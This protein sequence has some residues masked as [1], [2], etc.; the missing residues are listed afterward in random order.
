MLWPGTAALRGVA[1]CARARAQ[2]GGAS[3]GVGKF[4]RRACGRTTLRPGTA[5]LLGGVRFLLAAG[6]GGVQRVRQLSM[7]KKKSRDRSI[8]GV[9]RMLR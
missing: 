5:A 3:G 9:S 1:E 2:R 4:F 8:D 7:M 6:R